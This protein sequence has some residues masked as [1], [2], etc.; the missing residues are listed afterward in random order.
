[1]TENNECHFFRSE[2]EQH[3]EWQSDEGEEADDPFVGRCQFHLVILKIT[4][5]RV[6]HR[7]DHLCDILQGKHHEAVGL[8]VISEVGHSHMFA[9]QQ[10]V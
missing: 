6:H 9:D 3:A 4:E 5:D 1:M 10:F 8:L 2:K 7:S